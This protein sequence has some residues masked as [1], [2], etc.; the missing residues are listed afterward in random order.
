MSSNPEQIKEHKEIEQCKGKPIASGSVW[1]CRL[2]IRDV[3]LL[4]SISEQLMKAQLVGLSGLRHS[5][6][7]LMS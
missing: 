5:H 1:A 6:R 3:A 7:F 2:G 4:K